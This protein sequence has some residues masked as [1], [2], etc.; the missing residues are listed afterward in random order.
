MAPSWAEHPRWPEPP[1]F[2]GHSIDLA[3]PPPLNVN[4]LQ[5]DPILHIQQRLLLLA[6]GGPHGCP[7]R[8]HLLHDIPEHRRRIRRVAHRREAAQHRGTEHHRRSVRT[9]ENDGHVA[10][11]RQQTHERR[12][13]R[14]R[15]GEVQCADG[16]SG[17]V[18]LVDDVPRLECD[19]L[20][21]E[22][23]FAREVVQRG[24]LERA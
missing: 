3:P 16:V 19:R 1:S 20:E 15:P 23:V 6:S 10:R 2:I 8:R 22:R 17:V 7:R 11:V 5:K 24:V 18:Q 4:R 14:L 12:V 21:G 13:M 9:R